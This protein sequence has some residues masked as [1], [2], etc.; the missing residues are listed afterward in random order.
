MQKEIYKS[1]FPALT[2]FRFL[3]ASLVFIF[4]YNP[5]NKNTFLWGIC[6]ELYI[7]VGMFFVLSGFLITYNYY[8]SSQLAKGFFKKYFTKRFA[9]IYPVY[10]FLTILYFVYHFFKQPLSHF[11][12]QFFLNIFLL[13]GFSEKYLLTGI[14]QAWSLT[15][16]EC[17]Y[18][19]APFIYWFI[20]S[21]KIFWVQV[22]IL[23]LIGVSFVFASELRIP[24]FES[25]HFL[26]IATFFGRCF[27]FFVGIKLALWIKQ[28]RPAKIMVQ[29][30]CTLLGVVLILICILAMN[31]IRENSQIDFASSSPLGLIVNNILLPVGVCFLLWGLIKEK[32]IFSKILSNK[33]VIFL[34]K[35]SY[36][37]YLIHA[38]ILAD[39]ITRFSANNLLLKFIELQL[40]AIMLFLF[41]E[42][43]AN[44]LIRTLV[45]KKNYSEKHLFQ[46]AL[47]S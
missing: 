12:T 14:A 19:L 43:P 45:L 18:I 16:E 32:T 23:V 29:K 25:F 10:F 1:S 15:T 40:L 26:F 5:F 20:K 28:N 31:N 34:G 30:R 6:N 3:S 24:F 7:G 35:T 36:V 47:Q 22:V 8:D 11:A 41:I 2:G 37:F 46:K 13:K 27:E 42:K 9:R 38:G 4:H 39:F 17:F 33:I 44:E 21:K